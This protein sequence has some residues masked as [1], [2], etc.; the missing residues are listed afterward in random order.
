MQIHFLQNNCQ[1]LRTDFH[2]FAKM[3]SDEWKTAVSKGLNAFQTKKQIWEA[4]KSE[5]HRNRCDSFSR[6]LL[7]Q[8]QEGRSIVEFEKVEVAKCVQYQEIRKGLEAE[9]VKL[10]L[11]HK[12]GVNYSI[13]DVTK[14]QVTLRFAHFRDALEIPPDYIFDEN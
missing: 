2:F 10:V 9:G 6:K 5:E 1:E 3:T 4:R 8:I 7:G 14:K 12:E 11:A 13:Y